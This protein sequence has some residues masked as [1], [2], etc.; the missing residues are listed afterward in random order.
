VPNTTENQDGSIESAMKSIIAPPEE[1]IINEIEEEAQDTEEVTEPDVAETAES[2]EEDII[3]SEEESETEELVADSEDDE[4]PVEDAVQEGTTTHSVKVDGIN[5]EVS[6]DELKQGYSGQK[7]VQK[8]MQEAAAQ[9]KQAEEVYSSLLND[10]KQLTN[11]YEQ[12]T[13]G[14]LVRPPREPSREEFES[15][16]L[17]YMNKKLQFDEEK[18]GY[19]AKM[20]QLQVV[21]QQNSE[22]E[23]QAHKAYIQ[24]EMEELHK[25]LPEFGNPEKANKIKDK[26]VIA[27][28]AHYGYTEEEISQVMDHRAIQVLHDAMK[29]QDIIAGKS[30]AVAKTKKGKPVIKAGSKRLRDS[31]KQVRDQ[32]KAKLRQSGSMED[33]LGLILNS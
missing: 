31:K 16:P 2:E 15:D 20:A 27:G 26:L 13:N 8:G 22:A 29:Y 30:K 9:R 24:R 32:Q 14:D 7:Y 10:R 25:V 6:L 5:V 1:E 12:L 28:K 3:D 21:A 33:A 23:Q 11:L 19:D 4:D 17:G 18:Q